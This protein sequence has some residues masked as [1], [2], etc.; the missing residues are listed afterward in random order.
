MTHSSWQRILGFCVLSVIPGGLSAA[1]GVVGIDQNS[2]LAGS[3]TPG[4]APGFP[5]TISQSGS[6]RLTGNLIR[7]G[8]VR[9]CTASKNLGDGILLAAGGVATGNV[10][11]FNGGYGFYVPFGTATGNTAFL[12]KSFGISANCPSSLVGNT[13]AATGGGTIE[14]RGTDCALANNATRQ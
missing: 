11:S 8:S 4:D 3:V 9:D 1:D 2:A 14:T 13:I 10:S 12:N 5:V 7:N 6:Y